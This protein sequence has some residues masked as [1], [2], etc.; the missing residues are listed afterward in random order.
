MLLTVVNST[1]IAQPKKLNG[2]KSELFLDLELYL[3]CIFGKHY[4]TRPYSVPCSGDK[5]YIGESGR[6][7][8]IRLKDHI[9]EISRNRSEKTGLAEHAC[10]SSHYI[11]MD[12]EKLIHKEE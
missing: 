8:G 2:R 3:N 12:Q 11:C 10:S 7:F 9:N 6:S 1:P 5:V 4:F